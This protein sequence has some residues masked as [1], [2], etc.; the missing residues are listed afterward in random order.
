MKKISLILLMLILSTLVF[1]FGEVS[2]TKVNIVTCV[3]DKTIIVEME[4]DLAMIDLDDDNF[5]GIDYETYTT[6]EQGHGRKEIRQYY[7]TTNIDWQVKKK[8]G[9]I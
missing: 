7:M 6:E 1:S 4:N 8:S 9:Q 3:G 5:K 2:N